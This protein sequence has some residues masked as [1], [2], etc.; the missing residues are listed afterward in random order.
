MSQKKFKFRFETLSTAWTKNPVPQVSFDTRNWIDYYQIF[1]RQI[2]LVCVW[3]FFEFCTNSHRTHRTLIR[4]VVVSAI[5]SLVDFELIPLDS[6]CRLGPSI[7]NHSGFPL[8]SRLP[9]QVRKF[10]SWCS[11]RKNWKKRKVVE[12]IVILLYWVCSIWNNYLEMR[13]L[14]ARGMQHLHPPW[15]LTS[16]CTIS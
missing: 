13:K 3:Q 12:V 6:L 11:P 16:F 4:V 10:T 9:K 2:H 7:N 15:L 1:C 5:M 8:E 14:S